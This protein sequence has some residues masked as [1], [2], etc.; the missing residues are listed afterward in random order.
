MPSSV[1]AH[2]VDSRRHS[3]RLHRQGQAPERSGHLP[4]V[5]TNFD[6][7]LQLSELLYFA[8]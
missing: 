2:H 5:P 1:P 8:Q 3:V 4:T 7:R 6:L